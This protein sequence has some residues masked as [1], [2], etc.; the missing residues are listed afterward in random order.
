MTC[1]ARC[2][3]CEEIKNCRLHPTLGNVCTD[4]MD[5]DEYHAALNALFEAD[6]C[7]VPA[8]NP[9]TFEQLEDASL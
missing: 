1:L 9:F 8:F 6:N 5:T 4:C 3:E 2:V 7:D